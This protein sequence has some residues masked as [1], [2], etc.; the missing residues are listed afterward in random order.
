MYKTIIRRY[1][2]ITAVALALATALSALMTESASAG[3]ILNHN[4]TVVGD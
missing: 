1:A 4:Q 2:L 3:L